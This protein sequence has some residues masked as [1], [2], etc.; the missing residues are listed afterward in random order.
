MLA[1]FIDQLSN[2]I[3][4]VCIQKSSI[5]FSRLLA[6]NGNMDQQIADPATEE[7]LKS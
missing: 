3:L 5:P 6:D 4:T 7:H 2:K 1:N